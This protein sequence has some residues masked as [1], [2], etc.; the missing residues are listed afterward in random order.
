MTSRPP[1]M[2]P[3]G[4]GELERAVGS[5]SQ[6][7]TDPVAKLRYIRRSLADGQAADRHLRAVPSA[8]LRRMLYRILSV[9][10]LRHTIDLRSLGYAG[11]T[12]AASG[13]LLF[14]SRIA[15]AAAAL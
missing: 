15:V 11:R 12:E 7:I 5:V 6:N 9:A 3:D 14:L 1:A 2:A 8:Q 10:G 4:G 13:R